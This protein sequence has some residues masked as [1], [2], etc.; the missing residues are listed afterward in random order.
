VAHAALKKQTEFLHE[1]LSKVFNEDQLCVLTGKT[2]RG[3]SWSKETLSKALRIQAKC[4]IKGYE[5]L[6]DEH[7]PLPSIDAL[8]SFCLYG[9]KPGD[10]EI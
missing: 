2:K 7:F 3:Q 9:W 5:A 6:L 4:G 8:Q 1:R 10:K